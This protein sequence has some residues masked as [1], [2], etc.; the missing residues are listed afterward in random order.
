[1]S[2]QGRKSANSTIY[3]FKPASL[4]IHSVQAR[5]ESTEHQPEHPEMRDSRKSAIDGN[6]TSALSQWPQG[7][8]R[9]QEIASLH[10]D[11]L[12]VSDRQQTPARTSRGWGERFV[13]TGR[14]SF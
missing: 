13:H 6:V 11:A 5:D 14:P 9:L 7:W 8:Y 4:G 10:F 12:R 1:M 2:R 3:F